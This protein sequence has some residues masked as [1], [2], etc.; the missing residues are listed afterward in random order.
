MEEIAL[1]KIEN[2]YKKWIEKNV[3]DGQLSNVDEM[4]NISL[5]LF[6]K[7]KVKGLVSD[8]EDGDMLLFQCGTYEGGK[9][10]FLKFNI[11][12]QFIKIDEYEP[13]QLLMTL[14]FDPIECKSYDCWS[15]EFDDLEKWVENIKKTEGYKIA[16]ESTSKKF[17]MAF[18]QC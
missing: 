12:R 9:G 18:E 3:N 13:Y 4:I 14:F 17:E 2:E 5:T 6:Q 1:E 8:Y 11:T 7:L 16:K 10:K 15:N